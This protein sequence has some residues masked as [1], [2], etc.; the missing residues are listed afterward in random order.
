MTTLFRTDDFT[1]SM[2]QE[3]IEKLARIPQFYNVKLSP[4]KDKIA[5]YWDKTGR[6]ELYLMDLESKEYEQIS[7]GEVPRAI[8]SG[9]IWSKDNRNIIFAKDKDGNEQHDLYMLDTQSKEINQ[10]TET[11]Q[12][13]EHV[14]DVSP[15]GKQMLFLSTRNGQMNV[16]S[17]NL[18]NKEVTELTN[19]TRP[20]MGAKWSPTNDYILFGYSDLKNLQNI[21]VWIMNI[22]GSEKRK[23]ISMKDGSQEGVAGISKDGKTVAIT[24]DY[25]GVSKAGVYDFDTKEI[26]WL[27]DGKYDEVASVISP[28]GKYLVCLRNHKATI[29]PI[30]YNI[31]TKEEKKVDFPP[32]V[33]RGTELT[34]NSS[35]LIVTVNSSKNPSSLVKYNLEN[36]DV[37][38]LIPV[39]LKDLDSSLLVSDEYVEYPSTDNLTIGA[40]MSKPK[41]LE[42]G[43]KYPVLLQVHGG[44]TG[45]YF[46]NF[47]MFDQILANN[48]FIIF[49]PNFRGSTGYG[50]DFQDMNLFDIGGGDLEDV[51]AGVSYLKSLDY[52][53]SERIGIFGASYGGYM[54]FWA[55][56]KQPEIWKVGAASVG[57]TDWM[58]LYESSM[59]HFKHYQHILFGKPDENE[60]LYNE[61]SPIHLAKNLKTPLLITHGTHDPRCSVEQSRIFRDALLEFGWKEGKEGDKTFE[62]IEYSDVGHGGA[63]DQEFRIRSFTAQLD[64][65]KRRL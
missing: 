37:E 40:I 13:Q 34:K 18:E 17:L 28:D 60:E 43:K 49:K 3:L 1:L 20:V 47:S 9:F 48:G 12:Y 6:L 29:V 19:F 38:E 10:L 42:P 14:W 56:V 62:Y 44:P 33:V 54:T 64:F 27:S 59:P 46:R 31:E 50:R 7:A 65:F 5:F 36:G 8:R 39:E 45:Q 32:G 26:M 51:L 2:S 58:K 16:F 4:S 53:D 55:A 52:V 11:P 22:D 15:D 21:D 41:N 61:R 30:I 63:S 35:H 24:S 57:I 23:L 25:E